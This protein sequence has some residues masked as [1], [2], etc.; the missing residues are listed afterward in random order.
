MPGRSH[1]PGLRLRPIGRYRAGAL[2]GHHTKRAR[3]AASAH[4]REKTMRR[5]NVVLGS[6]A[7]V[8]AGSFAGGALAQQKLVLKVSDVHPAGYPTVVAVENLGKKLE[9]ATNGRLSVQ[10]FAAMHERKLK[11]LYVIGEAVDV[12]GWLGGYNFQ[13]A[14]SSG[15]VA[16]EAV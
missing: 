1:Q 8:A 4:V 7:L 13:W 15:W 9:K 2:F 6:L 5:R 3:K 14:W 11:G 16:G 10:M 12:T